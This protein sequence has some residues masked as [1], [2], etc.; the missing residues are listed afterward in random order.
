[1]ECPDQLE[2]RGWTPGTEYQKNYAIKNISTD[3]LRITYKQTASKAFSMDFAEV[4][5]LRPGMSLPL[6]VVFRPLKMQ[7][8]S[9]H[10]E[11]FVNDSS[12]IVL[13]EAYTPSTHIE[14]PGQ[15]DFGFVP[16]KETVI[17]PLLV[18]N[19]GDVKV[20]LSWSLGTPFSISPTTASILPGDE[21][22]FEVSFTP[23]EASFYSVDALCKLDSGNISRTVTV[24]LATLNPQETK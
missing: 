7:Q 9:D 22:S 21:V 14:C 8:Y 16:N 18:R 15:L 12:F 3:T 10:I 23:T 17:K 1:M 11:V 6:K 19:T 24:S 4:I 20:G 2:W 13:V 5:R